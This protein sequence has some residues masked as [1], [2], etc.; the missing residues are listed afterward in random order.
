VAFVREA[1]TDGAARV[2]AGATNVLLGTG[3]GAA[4][5]GL[6]PAG[7][8]TTGAG[9]AADR[10]GAGVTYDEGP[11]RVGTTTADVGCGDSGCTVS[12]GGG[13]SR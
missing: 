8:A 1:P 10:V 13:G 5:L 12:G 3:T 2:G 4:L 6:G 11:T 9:V 7:P